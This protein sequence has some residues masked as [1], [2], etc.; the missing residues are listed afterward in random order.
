MTNVKISDKNIVIPGGA[1]APEG[2]SF[3]ALF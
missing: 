2:E 3:L 1:Q